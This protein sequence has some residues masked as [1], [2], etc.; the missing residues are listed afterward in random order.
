M[1]ALPQPDKSRVSARQQ[2]AAAQRAGRASERRA[3]ILAAALDEFSARGFAAARLEDVAR[4]AG[5]AKGTIYL[6][7]K[8]KDALFRALVQ[9]ALVP[10]LN[11]FD[12]RPPVE[13]PTRALM[14]A[15]TDTFIREIYETP[16]I[17]IL[18][19]VIA[20]G[21]AF[22]DLVEFYY[23]EVVERGIAA[24]R[25]LLQRG[26]DREEIPYPGLARFPQLAIAPAIIAIIWNGLFGAHTELDARA[27]IATQLDL[28]FAERKTE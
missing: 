1:S 16:R 25:A 3:A 26:I 19:M 28:I 9:S 18:R 23:R 17:N 7:F 20:E 21:R 22:P 24:L 15:F 27:M 4:R 8:D 2:A 11:S 10:M 13:T 12:V 5:I 14:E 6:H